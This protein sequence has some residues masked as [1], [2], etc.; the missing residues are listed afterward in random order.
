VRLTADV[1]I[2]AIAATCFACCAAHSG[3]IFHMVTHTLDHG[4]PAMAAATVLSTAGLAS[5]GGKIGCGL[6]A[7][8]IGAKRVLRVDSASTS[9]R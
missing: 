2:A 3:P 4:V 7:D 8:W 9:E 5:P 6:G 1:T